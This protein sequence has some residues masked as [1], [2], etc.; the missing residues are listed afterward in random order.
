MVAPREGEKES[1]AW[2]LAKLHVLMNARQ[3][4]LFAQHP[5][6]H[7]PLDAYYSITLHRL[8][9]T[10]KLLNQ[11]MA[12]H[13]EFIHDVNINVLLSQVVLCSSPM[14]LSLLPSHMSCFDIVNSYRL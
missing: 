6:V 4:L 8:G 1:D 14:T 2:K 11:L 9:D 7:F 3:F 12:P 5:N 10:N 13:L